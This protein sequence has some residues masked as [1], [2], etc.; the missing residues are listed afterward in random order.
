MKNDT[1]GSIKKLKKLARS[2]K[3]IEISERLF[4]VI[5][6]KKNGR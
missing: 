1:R 6:G 2:K 3:Y 5:Y 4:A